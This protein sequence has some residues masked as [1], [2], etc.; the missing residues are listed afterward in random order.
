MHTR[1]VFAAGLLAAP[2]PALP[3]DPADLTASEAL[4]LIRQRKLTPVELTQACLKRIERLN[5]RLNAFITVTGEPAL[6]RARSLRPANAAREPLHGLPIGLKDL[7]DT[8]GVRTTAASRHWRERVPSTDAGVVRRL[9]SAG[10]VITGKANM[11]EFAYNFTS[12]TSAF[13]PARNPWDESCSPGGSSGGS[14]IAVASGMIVAALGSDTGGSIRLPASFCG[15]TGYKPTFGRVPTEGAAPL[16]WSLD[17]A[18]PMTRSARDAALLHSVLCGQPVKLAVVKDLR[19]GIPR[20]P[21]WQ[22]LQ[23]D[24]EGAM[25]EAAKTLQRLCR[26]VR[27]VTLPPLELNPASPLPKAYATVIFAEAFA[28]HRDMLA[29]HAELYHPGT[30]ASIELGKPIDA[31]TYIA[32]RRE[33]DRL[34]STAAT[35]LFRGADLLLTPTAPGPAFPLASN[36]SLD[37]LRNTAP[38]NLYGLPTIAIPCGFGKS[39]LPIGLQ[40]TGPPGADAAVLSAAA[41]F[42]TETDFHQRRPKL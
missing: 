29:R 31:A 6:E 2:L 13:G 38:W 21:Y 34:R 42:Q 23:S 27:D 35:E 40:L 14:A 22:G 32:A 36:P 39:G 4:A 30:R 1:R 8:A 28:F 24:V 12:E 5:P 16:A 33:M 41:A 15:I 26:E 9:R 17:H 20:E 3:T 19:I 37:F 18:G 11:D 7:Y 10:A 25:A